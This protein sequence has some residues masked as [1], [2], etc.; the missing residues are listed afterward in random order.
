VGYSNTHLFLLFLVA[1]TALLSYS[2]W[3]H[4]LIFS[5]RVAQIREIQRQ[6][7]ASLG[8][9]LHSYRLRTTYQLYNSAILEAQMGGALFLICAMI[10]ILTLFFTIHHLWLLSTGTTTNES[11]KWEDIKDALKIQEIVVLDK[12]DPYMY[13]FSF[14]T[15]LI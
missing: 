12:D 9:A 13:F 10:S 14:W 15:E 1:N 3:L 8:A 7:I 5:N 6:T 11:L 4:Y 2:T